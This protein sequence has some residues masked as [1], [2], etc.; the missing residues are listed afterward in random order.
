MNRSLLR[1][2]PRW[3][4]HRGLMALVLAMVL[5]PSL[6]LSG[7]GYHLRGTLDLPEA[8]TPIA[9]DSSSGTQGVAQRLQ[10][11][12]G[13][14][15]AQPGDR[16]GLRIRLSNL[17]RDEQQTLYVGD[18]GSQFSQTLSVRADAMDASGSAIWVNQR[19]SATTDYV[20]DEE[21]LTRPQQQQRLQTQLEQELAEKILNRIAALKTADLGRQ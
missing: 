2:Q 1:L 15:L 4:S 5:A 16:P 13:E 10:R 14:D 3:M 18:D 6:V 11:R 21:T 12:L 17:R 8:L 19:I 20:R 7:C 9:V